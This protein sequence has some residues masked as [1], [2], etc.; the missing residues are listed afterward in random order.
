[1][2]HGKHDDRWAALY[3]ELRMYL[4]KN[5][6]VP[7]RGTIVTPRNSSGK[8]ADLGLWVQRQRQAYRFMSSVALPEARCSILNGTKGWTWGAERGWDAQLL[9]LR[10]HLSAAGAAALPDPAEPLGWWAFRQRQMLRTGR[11]DAKQQ[12]LLKALPHNPFKIT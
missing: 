11:L 4:A 6:R 2:P 7:P 10:E 9:K 12:R 3:G 8:P 1:M 5:K